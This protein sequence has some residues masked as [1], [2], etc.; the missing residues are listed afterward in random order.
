MNNEYNILRN[1]IINQFP[2]I[3]LISFKKIDSGILIRSDIYRNFNKD[4]YLNFLIEFL[5]ISKFKRI[6]LSS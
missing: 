4:E 3:K 6:C 2:H 1:L 5:K